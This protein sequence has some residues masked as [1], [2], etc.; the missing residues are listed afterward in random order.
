MQSFLEHDAVEVRMQEQEIRELQDEWEEVR[1]R[2]INVKDQ[3]E[4]LQK[5]RDAKDAKTKLDTA[6]R[7][8]RQYM[9]DARIRFTTAAAAS[10]TPIVP[11]TPTPA[12]TPPV[13][14]VHPT[15][16]MKIEEPK[17]FSGEMSDYRRWKF[18]VGNVMAVRT[19]ID[20]Y[21]KKIRYTG[22]RMEGA[23]LQ[24]YEMYCQKRSELLAI[25]TPTADEVARRTNEY[26]D[27]VNR[28]DETFRDPL[29]QQTYRNKVKRAVQ[30]KKSFNEYAIHFLDLVNRANLDP[31]T[32]ISTLLE[33]LDPNIVRIWKPVT[34]P[35]N[36][37]EV[38]SSIR[39]ALQVNETLRQAERNARLKSSVISTIGS[40]HI[41]RL[42][43]KSTYTHDVDGTKPGAFAVN[44]EKPSYKLR[45]EN[46][47]CTRCGMNAHATEK[48]MIYP[49]TKS[50]P[51]NFKTWKSMMVGKKPAVSVI[52]GGDD[53]RVNID[54]RSLVEN[55]LYEIREV[56]SDEDNT[57]SNESAYLSNLRYVQFRK[58]PPHFLIPVT[59]R[60]G[61]GKS[62]IV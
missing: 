20:T 43:P 34:L 15:T 49:R 55:E 50:N 19:N 40:S 35:D 21:D 16:P 39:I 18:E 46:G 47:W 11:P 29:E 44:P 2:S 53:L 56:D 13:V 37:Q 9:K 22:S 7:D 62:L 33:S 5:D 26:Q 38:V 24:W 1:N 28:C 42:Q 54:Q 45:L 61:K 10:T 12:A 17:K 25:I 52:R 30:G 6:R 8:L 36:Y 27:F 51:E 59:I 60:T 57:T 48:C 41:T 32:Q 14:A 31:N 4:V 23:A 3:T 58:Q